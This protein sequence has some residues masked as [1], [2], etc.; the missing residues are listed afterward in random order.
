MSRIVSRG[1]T[2][3]LAVVAAGARNAGRGQLRAF[4]SAAGNNETSHSEIQSSRE[5][6]RVNSGIDN[7]EPERTSLHFKVNHTPGALEDVL[8][9]FKD[10]SINLTRIESRP[11]KFDASTSEFYVDFE[12]EA[13]DP[14]VTS[15]LDALK[16]TCKEM[17]VTG[18]RTVPWFPRHISDLDSFSQKTLDAGA[19]L[20]SDH[21]GFSDMTY[22]TRRAAIVENAGTYKFGQ[23]IPRVDYSEDEIKTWG[24]VYRRLKELFP[25]HAC[26]EYNQILEL[27]EHNCGYGD[28]NIPQ[29]EDVSQFLKKCTGFQLRPVA[30]LLSARDFLNALAFRTFFS[31][32]YIRHHS[33]PL[34]T[35][36]PDVVHELMGH[37]P[38]LADPDFAELSQ[39]Y[40]LAS[41]GAS[42]SDIVRL[43]TCYWFT[44]EFGV[45]RQGE[46]YKAYGA[47]LL[48]S[49]GE[50]EWSCAKKA[51]GEKGPQYLP[52]NPAVAAEFEYPITEYQPTY[53]VADSLADA[54]EKLKE[55]SENQIV[56]PFRVSYLPYSQSIH[57][58]RLVKRDTYE[59]A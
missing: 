58:D 11:S 44:V 49:F 54:T 23:E 6:L 2:R 10:N 14:K 16:A 28:D 3:A 27:L 45:Y 4:G 24:A 48:S 29:L 25:K 18:P 8:K 26:K 42:D 55:F 15:L 34:Y 32:Q 52:W 51:E 22:R 33:M 12:G 53:F 47:G 5:L 30:G 38:L 43:A 7:G 17:Q 39:Q 13:T 31:T 9:H 56:R 37:A 20:E 57:T 41:L 19:E 36:E 59:G 1:Q 21:P 50:M 46:D 35:P 40:G